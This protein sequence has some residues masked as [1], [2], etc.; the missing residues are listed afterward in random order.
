MMYSAMSPTKSPRDKLKTYIRTL[1]E[2]V[3]Q[4]PELPAIMLRE[5][6][7][8]GKNLPEMVV[9]DLGRM[10]GIITEILDEGTRSGVF[11]ETAP[12]IVHL[13]IVG[14]IVLFKMSDPIRSKYP[15]LTDT[16]SRLEHADSRSAVAEIEKL[17][18]N[19][20]RK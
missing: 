20:V 10:V 6:A 3:D 5:Q 7:S 2:L 15:A 11:I 16:L 1:A 12:F 9:E 14:A 13:M 8:G 17:V 18:L 19:A 4:N